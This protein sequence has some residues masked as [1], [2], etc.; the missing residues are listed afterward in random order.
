[1]VLDGL[2]GRVA[3]LTD[4]QSEFGAQLDSLSDMISF[5]FAPGLLV[6]FSCHDIVSLGRL[7]WVVCFIIPAC[8]ALRLARFNSQDENL[9]KV[10]FRGLSSPMGAGVIVCYFWLISI[11]PWM[12]SAFYF[13]LGL[14][15][16]IPLSLL[17]VSLLRYRSFKDFDI[18]GKVPF[19]V[20]LI[21]LLV[22][23]FVILFPAL[24]L[25][26]IF[27]AYALSGPV[28]YVFIRFMR[29]AKA[30]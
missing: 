16:S 19:Y 3:R 26:F 30:G 13:W 6:Y 29:R 28:S 9:N 25:F 22:L 11:E 8:V 27:A 5:G 21:L 17:E 2:D 12:Q 1:M 14:F 15:L 7:P 4:T 10:F 24:T 18:R 23:A 20:L